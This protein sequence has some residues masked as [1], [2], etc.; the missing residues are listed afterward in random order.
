MQ[1]RLQKEYFNTIT[2][3]VNFNYLHKYPDKVV[4]LS[5][6][7]V[8]KV[9]STYTDVGYSTVITAIENLDKVNGV[10][11]RST[12]LLEGTS[13]VTW[14]IQMERPFL[15]FT[16]RAANIL[17]YNY[18]RNVGVTWD[19]NKITWFPYVGGI[20][21]NS[22]GDLIHNMYRDF[23]QFN[24]GFYLPNLQVGHI[25]NSGFMPFRINQLNVPYIWTDT[26]GINGYGMYRMLWVDLNVSWKVLNYDYTRDELMIMITTL[27][28][29]TSTKTL[30]I[31]S[32]NLAKLT[33]ED[34]KIA[35]DKG[36]TLA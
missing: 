27:K 34:I 7:N 13:V 1:F 12:D 3:Y 23:P 11:I 22:K 10:I 19:S 15:I 32:T 24:K 28:P 5:S 29:T 16:F 20:K 36:W 2:D 18:I 8:T 31:G 4:E 25:G 14:G 17:N 9:K 21:P 35:T 26:A 6:L 30:T 33:A